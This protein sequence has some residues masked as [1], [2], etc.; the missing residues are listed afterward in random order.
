MAEEPAS[1]LEE[2]RM[3]FLSHL[4]ELRDRVRNAAICFVG[5]FIVCFYFANEIYAWLRAPLFE[6][7][8]RKNAALVAAGKPSLGDIGLASLADAHGRWTLADRRQLGSDTL[9]V[10]YPAPTERT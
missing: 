10:Y 3:T 9:E 5:A 7:W 2:S 4:R 8:A 1:E 6:V